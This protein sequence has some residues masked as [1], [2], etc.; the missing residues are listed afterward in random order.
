MNSQG[1]RFTIG[2]VFILMTLFSHAQS[3]S[4]NKVP[5]PEIQVTTM[6]NVKPEK[7]VKPILDIRNCNKPV[8]PGAALRWEFQG[9][10]YL[11]ITASEDGR[12]ENVTLIKSSG[13]KILDA[14][15]INKLQNCQIIEAQGK[16]LSDIIRYDWIIDGIKD[17]PAEIIVNSCNPLRNIRFAGEYEKGVGIVTSVYVSSEGLPKTIS[18][19]WSS[20][21]TALDKESMDFLR[22]CKFK[23]ASDA[24]KNV[25]GPVSFRFFPKEQK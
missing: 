25:D 19:E 6:M 3:T 23:P 18:L 13:W 17:K 20:G 22:S 9:K 11:E 24:G 4:G 10:T 2:L 14:E 1:L 12:L 7:I 5:P 8:Y 21:Q 15:L 16:K